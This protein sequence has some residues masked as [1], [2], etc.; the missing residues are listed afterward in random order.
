MKR[1]DRHPRGCRTGAP[2]KD[3]GT[4]FSLGDFNYTT[5]GTARASHTHAHQ[6]DRLCSRPARINGTLTNDAAG[7]EGDSL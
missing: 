4:K 3:P 5:N 7:G 2:G 6:R 1:A